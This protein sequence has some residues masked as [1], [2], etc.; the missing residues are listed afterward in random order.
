MAFLRRCENNKST[1]TDNHN[2]SMITRMTTRTLMRA[3]TDRVAQ[4]R[5]DAQLQLFRRLGIEKLND[6][7]QENAFVIKYL[8]VLYIL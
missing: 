3:S 1:S 5:T 8:L 7:S 2:Q 6:E 4:R